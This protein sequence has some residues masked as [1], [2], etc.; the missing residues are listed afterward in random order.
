MDEKIRV[1]GIAPYENMTSLMEEVAREYPR[2]ELTMFVGD[3]EQGL[4][5]ARNNLYGNYDVVISRGGT[6]RILQKDL[7]L[8]VIEVEISMFDVL[9][10]LRITAFPP[11]ASPWSRW[12]SWWTAPTPWPRRWATTSTCSPR[13]RPPRWSLP[14]NRSGRGAIRRCC[15]T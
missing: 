5:V 4:E 3:M 7:D 6:A 2:L 14:W 13:R 1:L 12:R 11:D 10:T 15:A 8:P 9:R